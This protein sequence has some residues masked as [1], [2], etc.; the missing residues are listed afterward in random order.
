MMTEFG[1]VKLIDELEKSNL[2]RRWDR[3]KWF[4][5]KWEDSN[6]RQLT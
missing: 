2:G 4:R 5:N 6:Y 1:D 3:N